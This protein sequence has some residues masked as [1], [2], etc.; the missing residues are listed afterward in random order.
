MEREA[1]LSF[2]TE[3]LSVERKNN[4]QLRVEIGLAYGREKASLE[5]LK[6]FE[7]LLN[8]AVTEKEKLKAENDMLRLHLSESRHLLKQNQIA[9]QDEV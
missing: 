1:K 3:Q 4:K 7:R 2:L 5:A 8:D 6:E 9:G